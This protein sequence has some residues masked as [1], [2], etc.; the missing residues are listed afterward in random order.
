MKKKK[1]KKKKNRRKK[2]KNELKTKNEHKNRQ[3]TKKIDSQ[4]IN[5]FQNLF[6]IK[7]QIQ[8]L[9][10]SNYLHRILNY[11]SN[12][13]HIYTTNLQKSEEKTTMNA[14]KT[15]NLQCKLMSIYNYDYTKM[16]LQMKNYLR[17]IINLY[18]QLFTPNYIIQNQLFNSI[19]QKYQSIPSI[20]YD[21]IMKPIIQ[22]T[23]QGKKEPQNYLKRK[24]NSFLADVPIKMITKR[25]I[26]NKNKKGYNF[27][28]WPCVYSIR[29]S[30]SIAR[31]KQIQQCVTSR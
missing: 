31:K 8:I 4:A 15:K 20:F 11:L 12:Y 26:P 27:K 6:T 13:L 14:I 21:P 17:H 3:K 23:Y 19:I 24:E 10:N 2:T 5:Y 18:L 22:K 7:L 9:I 29:T 25:T 30:Y 1:I 16:K 28:T